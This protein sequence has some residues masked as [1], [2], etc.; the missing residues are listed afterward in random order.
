MFL[1]IF[2][3]EIIQKAGYPF[4]EHKVTTKDGFILTL[5]RIPN[6]KHPNPKK[7]P[8]FL[9]HGLISSAS[10]FVGLGKNSLRM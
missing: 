1:Y 8:V 7:N 9:Q 10:C 5:F 4:A 3:P 2:Q 6:T